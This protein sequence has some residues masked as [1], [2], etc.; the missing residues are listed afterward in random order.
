MLDNTI[1]LAV[2][3]EGNGT[4]VNQVYT[5]DEE[6]LNRAVYTGADNTLSLRNTLSTYRTK[7][8]K[9]GNF[10]GVGKAEAKFTQD[11]VVPGVD[12]STTLVGTAIVDIS[13]S[14][15]VGM[16]A[17]LAMELRNRAIAWLDNAIAIRSTEKLE[18]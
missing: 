13:T 17:E 16:A 18:A 5:R 6:Y 10:N 3:V 14:F 15:P 7:P 2:D 12:L 8:K 1:T 11:C 4:L 9:S